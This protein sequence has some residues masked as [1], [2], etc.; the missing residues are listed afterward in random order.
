[1]NRKQENILVI[2]RS[3]KYIKFTGISHGAYLN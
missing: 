2:V 3:V 1:L